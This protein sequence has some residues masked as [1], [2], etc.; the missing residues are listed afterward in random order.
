MLTNSKLYLLTL[1]ALLFSTAILAQTPAQVR[2][3]KKFVKSCD[4]PEFDESTGFTR[5]LNI[6]HSANEIEIR[7]SELS[8][9][10]GNHTIITYNKGQYR[11]LYYI[12]KRSF[13]FYPPE[14]RKSPY[15]K[16]Q[17]N[18]SGLDTIL[19]KI[20]Q[21]GV[22][23]REDPGVDNMAATDLGIIKVQYK[24]NSD[25]GS[26]QFQPPHKSIKNPP[27]PDAYKKMSKI[28]GLF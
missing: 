11:A 22:S 16:Y 7:L 14:P 28:V 15:N 6:S 4:C 17:I 27:N 20:I 21:A 5:L 3:W 25:T 12:T 23:K 26:Y 8:M 18:S 19:N 13:S 2:K 24:I 10:H 1:L 9:G